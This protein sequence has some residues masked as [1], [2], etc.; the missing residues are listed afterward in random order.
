MAMKITQA[1]C[2]SCGD[3]ATVCPT[4]SIIEKGGM[5]KINKDTCT[6]CEGDFDSPKCVDTCPSGDTCIVYA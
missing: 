1:E 6:E 5:F 2:S 4:K 3:C